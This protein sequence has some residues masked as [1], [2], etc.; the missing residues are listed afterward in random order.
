MP[1]ALTK[2]QHSPSLKPQHSTAPHI[3]PNYE[4]KVQCDPTEDKNKKNYQ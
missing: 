1:N 2:F 4:A 3:I